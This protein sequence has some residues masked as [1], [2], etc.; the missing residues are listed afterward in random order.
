MDK[1]RIG[2]REG[3]HARK[4]YNREMV[5]SFF[6]NTKKKLDTMDSHFSDNDCYPLRDI[7]FFISR[8]RSYYS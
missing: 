6:S 3:N 5:P 4:I 1:C 7:L 2:Y 8:D